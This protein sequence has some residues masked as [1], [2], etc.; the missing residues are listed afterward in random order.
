MG[1]HNG[2]SVDAEVDSRY[3]EVGV[4][5]KARVYVLLIW[6]KNC[7]DMDATYRKRGR[8]LI[9]R[10]AGRYSSTYV[11]LLSILDGY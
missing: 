1:P 7:M 2:G 9:R 6:P 5:V 8:Q 11:V 3:P 10:G 4:S